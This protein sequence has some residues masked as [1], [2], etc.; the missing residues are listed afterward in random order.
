MNGGAGFPTRLDCTPRL[1]APSKFKSSPLRSILLLIAIGSADAMRM[2]SP[3]EPAPRDEGCDHGQRRLAQLPGCC[4][5]RAEGRGQG[6]CTCVC[7]CFWQRI[8]KQRK[9]QKESPASVAVAR[10]QELKVQAQPEEL[11]FL[12]EP[13]QMPFIIDQD[14]SFE[15]GEAS[16]EEEIDEE[17]GIFY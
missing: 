13:T 17:D 4:G 9:A 5:I 16:E 7:T 6:T 3:P 15:W 11:S 8:I 2:R 14:L 10:L 12:W 1:S